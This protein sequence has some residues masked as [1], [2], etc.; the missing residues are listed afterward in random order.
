MNYSLWNL[1][2]RK[3][4]LIIFVNVFFVSLV[5][6]RLVLKRVVQNSNIAVFSLSWMSEEGFPSLSSDDGG[7]PSLYSEEFTISR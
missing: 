5:L 2:N 7:V 1:G 6:V 3:I 4:F